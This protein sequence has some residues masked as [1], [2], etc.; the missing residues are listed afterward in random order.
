M[1]QLTRKIIIAFCLISIIPLLVFA[2]L[3][4]PHL[5]PTATYVSFILPVVFIT[6]IIVVLGLFLLVGLSKNVN[7]LSSSANIIA[8]GDLSH[9]VQVRDNQEVAELADSLNKIAQRLRED[10]N[11]LETHAILVERANRELSRLN[12]LKSEFVSMVSHELRAP[13]INIKQSS[14]LILESTI[15]QIN[16]EQKRCLVIVNHSADRL[17]KLISDL[18][19][20]SKIE[21]GKFKLNRQMISIGKVI[22]E[23]AESLERWR[24]AKKIRL[25][26]EIEPNLPHINADPDRV[27]QIL[28]NLL[29]NAIK[30]TS[31]NGQI[32]IKAEVGEKG[33]FLE[34]SVRDTGI[35]IPPEQLDKIFE[36]F[37]HAS[38]TPSAPLQG[39]GLGLSITREIVK[40][41]GGNIWVESKQGQGSRFTFT[42][43][44]SKF[45]PTNYLVKPAK[46]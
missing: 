41:H 25:R 2:Y 46:P 18:L 45:S 43:P 24:E 8:R 14:S 23:A 39:I 28:V 33:D 12:K 19:D 9:S 30:F 31:A 6:A 27:N 29:S 36:R 26:L 38:G 5:L 4:L 44:F 42:L 20:I 22:Q 11:D 16:E 37:K 40:M 10:M 32:T 7:K 35:G 13:L 15:G 17:L 21:A 3:M 1:N 34:I